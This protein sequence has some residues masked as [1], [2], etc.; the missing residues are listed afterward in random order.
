MTATAVIL[1]GGG[2]R[3]MGTPKALLTFEGE[4]FLNR[5]VRIFSAQA[6]RVIVV[7]GLQPLSVPAGAVAV[8]NPNA[9]TGQ[10]SSLQRGLQSLPPDTDAV[11]FTPVDYPAIQPSTIDLLSKALL[12][13]DDFV[14][15]RYDGRHG[16]P[17]LF[18]A[19][20]CQE[21]LGLPP[22]R[23]ARDIVHAHRERTRYVDVDDP[24][25]VTDVDTPED[26]SFL[27]ERAGR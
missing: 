9:E 12:P 7:T 21:F 15:P 2:S 1:A 10:L 6:C 17:V 3:R 5:L 22:D 27:V 4:T 19:R 25:V 11:F 20:L 23:S 14:I 8:H 26:Y 16:H 18:A 13:G 24:G